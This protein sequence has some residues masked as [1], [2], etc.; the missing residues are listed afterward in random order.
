MPQFFALSK[1]DRSLIVA[2]DSREEIQDKVEE[3]RSK[4]PIFY[5]QH[6]APGFYL[7]E[8]ADLRKAKKQAAPLSYDL[9]LFRDADGGK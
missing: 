8:A 1:S 5:Q 7:I 4:Y 6:I 9:P 2:A 3:M